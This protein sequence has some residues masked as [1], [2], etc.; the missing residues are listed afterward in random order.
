MGIL[1]W[2]IGHKERDFQLDRFR[3]ELEYILGLYKKRDLETSEV[4]KQKIESDLVA[5]Y[6]SLAS[7]L[8]K[9]YLRD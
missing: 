8:K 9:I 7:M 6:R 2:I 5:R 1:G 3:P 4:K